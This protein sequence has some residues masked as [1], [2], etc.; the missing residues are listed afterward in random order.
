[1]D[2]QLQLA[3]KKDKSTPE[4]LKLFRTVMHVTYST[5]FTFLPEDT[6][7]NL[8]YSNLQSINWQEII[9]EWSMLSLPLLSPLLSSL[10]PQK[11]TQ[12]TEMTD[13]Y[14]T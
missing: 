13:S 4:V 1:M 8:L 9:S 2:A 11:Y 3:F 10:L 12:N 7:V 5:L 14:Y 6:T